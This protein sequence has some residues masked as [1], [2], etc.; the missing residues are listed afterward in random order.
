LLRLLLPLVLSNWSIGLAAPGV[1][2]DWFEAPLRRH[3][4]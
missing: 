1:T 3:H 2:L 4:R